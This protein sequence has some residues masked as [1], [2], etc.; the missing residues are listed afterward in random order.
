MQRKNKESMSLQTNA[1]GAADSGWR[2]TVKIVVHALILAMIVRIF[3]YQPFNIPSGSMKSTLLVGDYLFVSKLSY[4]FSRY[5]FPWG[6]IPFKGRIFASEPQRGDVVVFKLPRDNS[7]DYIK[8]VIG[9]PGDEIYMRGGVLHINGKA[10]SKVR[11][12]DFVTPEEPRPIPRF[13]ETLPNGVKYLVLD[14]VSNGEFDDTD[15]YKVPPGHYFMMGDN[16]DNSTDS[17]VQSPRFGVGYVPYDNLVGRAE[18]IF[19]SAAVDDP[20]AFRLTSPWTWPMD[21][22]WRRI[23]SLVR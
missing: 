22:R 16:R 8:R 11:K 3:L 2:E 14:A 9:L 15:V 23:F 13:E 7:T 6:I 20:S 12:D 4:G 5:S 10:I 18:V 19:F 21:I 17:R 1:N